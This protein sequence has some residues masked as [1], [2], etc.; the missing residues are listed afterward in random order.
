MTA[1]VFD[2]KEFSIHDGPGGRVT[3]FFKGCPLRCVWC[4]NPEGLTKAPQLMTKESLC[5]KC[6]LCKKSSDSELFKLYGR[7]PDACPEGLITVSGRE[8]TE[9]ALF[10]KLIGYRDM[11]SL[12]KGGVTFSGGE[13]LLYTDF[14]CSLSKRLRAE[15]IH[16]AV[17]TSGYGKD[18]EKLCDSVDLVI[19]DIKLMDC[20]LHK[21]YAGVSNELI[22]KNAGRLMDSSK[23]RLF[24]TPLIP[25][26]TDTVEN[27]SGIERFLKG[28]PWEKL[29]YNELAGAKYPMLGMKYKYEKGEI[30]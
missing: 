30:Q 11:L 10:S 8:Y 22:L 28:Q 4:H 20:E 17:E 5:K 1:T 29:P 26:I 12:T 19:M 18:F 14:I 16:T 6:F 23:E 7:D 2:I 3:V 25:G 21:K 24:R 9:D 13:P 15:G 27:L